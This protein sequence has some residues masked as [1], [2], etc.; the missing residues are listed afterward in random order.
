MAE[1]RSRRPSPERFVDM[2]KMT[3]FLGG[4]AATLLLTVPGFGQPPG[5]ERFRGAD[6][7]ANEVLVEVRNPRAIPL[8]RL[9]S[10]ADAR[11]S[12]LVGAGNIVRLRSQSRAV[13]ALIEA[14][15]RDPDVLV[16]EPNYVLRTTATPNDPS[17]TSLWGLNNTGQTISSQV[18]LAGADIDAT[19]AW[20]TT[21]GSASVVVGVVDTGVNYNHPDLAANMW[22][23]PASFTVTVGGLNIT[24]AAGTS[25]FNAILKT[26]DP[27]DDNNHGTHVAGT[28]GAVGN[29]GT[30][31][32]GVNWTTSI[33]GLK[34]L[35]STGSGNTSDAINAIEF[36]NQ[37]KSKGI[38]NVRVLN[39]SWGGG[40]YSS[41]LLDAIRRADANQIL[42]VASAGNNGANTDTTAYYPSNYD[43][44]N[45]ISV[46]ATDNR[47]QKASFSNYGATT[48]DLG[49]PGVSILSTLISGYGWMSGTSMA[50]PHVSGAAALVLAACTLDNAG[51]RS[52]LLNST[53]PVASLS[54]KA[55]TGGRLN[56]YQ[57]LNRCSAPASP[58]FT[59]TATSTA[60][61]VVAGQSVS[62]GLTVTALNGFNSTAT[63]STSALPAGVTASFSPTSVVGSGSATLAFA[64]SSSTVAGTYAVTVTAVAGSLVKSFVYTL[65]VSAAATAPAV[66][67][68]FSL[69]A[70]PSSV[71]VK[72][73][74]QA[75]YV[76]T[77]TA[78][79]GFT[80]AVTLTVTGLP[81]STTAS[82]TVNPV[83]G[84][85]TSTLVIR[86]SSST[87]RGAVTLTVTGSSPGVASKSV[88]VGLRVN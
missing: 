86:T 83:N 27:M 23:A 48:V 37:L 87:P 43:S 34:F 1:F 82:F 68:S 31:V 72:R 44:P 45:V 33:I 42:F 80:G 25:G 7:V 38:A 77:V 63:F 13:L 52:A 85:G 15:S 3:W 51:L 74:G 55:V 88:Q 16:V 65:T 69:S 12:E 71:T 41:L 4:L 36:A 6:V 21:K 67:P 53:E 40:G 73:G 57:A 75:S 30:G 64:T 28:I 46:A 5:L 19:R 70:S 24:C 66:S 35:S 61:S 39:N 18:G 54:G 10:L 20:D 14:L 9:L 8:Q 58:D 29:N 2:R 59:L 79:G 22:K 62:T 47:D 32:A 78:S 26:C 49:A 60:G 76:V 50:A 81:S 56:V 11:Q 84:S 17:F